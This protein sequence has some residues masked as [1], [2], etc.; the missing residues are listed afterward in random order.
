M[1]TFLAVI[2]FFTVLLAAMSAANGVA[3][4]QTGV[5]AESARREGFVRVAEDYS[6]SGIAMIGK[7]DVSYRIENGE[8]RADYMNRTV[9][10]RGIVDA[11]KTPGEPV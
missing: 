11:G 6:N 7:T 9:V 2:A 10:V 1:L 3:K 4:A 5:M 8:V